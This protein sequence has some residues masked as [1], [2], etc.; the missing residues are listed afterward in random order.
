MNP[1]MCTSLE[2][3]TDIPYILV[4]DEYDLEQIEK[5]LK[6]DK[7]RGI[8]GSF[9]NGSDID[10]MQLKCDLRERG[11]T[12][13]NF[14]PQLA[15]SDLK[16]NSDGMVPV[17]VQDYQTHEVLMLA[18]MNE[19]AFNTTIRIGKMTYW[20]RSRN[21]LWT[22]GM[23][24]GHI[25]YVKSLTADC[26]YDTILA[27]VSQVGPACH[28]GERSC[29]FHNIIEKEYTEKNPLRVLE[30]E[31]QSII[32]RKDNP[33]GDSFTDE[34]FRRGLDYIL[35]NVGK[36]ATDIIISAKSENKNNSRKE[37]ADF[38]YDLMILMAQKELTWDDIT[39]ELSQR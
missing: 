9:I 12:M 39:R 3:M 5:A 36:E 31:Y 27:K 23:T 37:I 19:E 34:M 14:E 24:S 4:Q 7:I 16:L 8:Y 35:Q 28:T 15:W 25:Q 11:I 20:S 22:K 33:C 2:S 21:E 32:S 6:S 30:T 10:I 17:I 1:Q 38:I 18:Y 13:D 29:F 26:D